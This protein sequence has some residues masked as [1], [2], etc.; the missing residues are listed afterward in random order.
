[1]LD[2]LLT[3]Q[4]KTLE[5]LGAFESIEELPPSGSS[6]RYFRIRN[7]EKSVIAAWNSDLNENSAFI[8]FS[9]YFSGRG[10]SVPEIIADFPSLGLYF[11]SDLGDTTLYNLLDPLVDNGKQREKALKVFYPQ[12]LEKLLKFQTSITFEKKY[13]Y[14]H[15]RFDKRS[16]MWDLN[17]F[18]YFFLKLNYI[19]FNENALENDFEAFTTFLGNVSSDFFMYR[20]F[21][22]RNIMVEGETLSFIDYQ[23]GRLGPLQY[24]VASLL[25]DAKAGLSTG[26]RE[27][28]LDVYCSLLEERQIMSAEEFR[29]AF[30][31]TV[32]IRIMQAMGTY[33]YRGYYER[34]HHFLQSVPPAVENLKSL[35][36]FICDSRWPELSSIWNYIAQ[37]LSP[38][39]QFEDQ[40]QSK[41]KIDISSISLKK[42][43]PEINSEH[44]GGFV[45]DCRFLPN[46]GRIEKYKDLNGM[47][48]PVAR[49]LKQQK[50][51]ELFLTDVFSILRRAVKQYLE[52]GFSHL[53]VS[54]GCTGGQHRSVYCAEAVKK[55]LVTEFDKRLD[56]SIAHIELTSLE[57]NKF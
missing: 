37:T 55:M 14:P 5:V 56:I 12:A 42:H 15:A 41:L 30:Y 7:A 10:L 32:A 40:N 27:K 21:Q 25:Y 20:D 6:R 33:G 48:L 35:L 2:V 17:Y 19:P 47:D 16:M 51:V 49:Y 34:K 4:S 23:G 45:F 44:G 3:V 26:E 8:Y 36:P 1:M 54:F 38:S 11:I 29:A 43:Y 18:K 13:C 31:H 24:D 46:P 50:E 53:S 9:R 52:R 57:K 28:L 22:S 39:K